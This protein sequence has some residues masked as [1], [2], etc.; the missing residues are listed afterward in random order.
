I[1]LL[2]HAI[3]Q[4]ATDIHLVVKRSPI[5][6]IHGE[7]TPSNLP[8]LEE[9]DVE[10]LIFGMMSEDQKKFFHDHQDI[11]LSYL[12]IKDFYFRVNAH[13]EKWNFAAN[14]RILPT[15]IPTSQQLGLPSIVEKLARRRKGL[16]LIV[17]SAGSG[18]TTTFN[19]MV[20]MI[21]HERPF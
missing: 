18:K 15:H 1:D 7:L 3:D 20:N 21:N 2:R 8:V 14:I 10:E 13:I 6:R 12:G 4:K 11:D 16:I 5:L 9:K 19:Y 17:G